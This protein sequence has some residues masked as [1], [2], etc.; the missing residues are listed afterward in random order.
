MFESRPQSVPYILMDRLQN[1]TIHT[2]RTNFS[3]VA[4]DPLWMSGAHVGH[5]F[6]SFMHYVFYIYASVFAFQQSSHAKKKLIKFISV[7]N[8]NKNCS[9]WT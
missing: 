3:F 6:P 1:N 8:K 7:A 4:K 5:L 2:K 9:N